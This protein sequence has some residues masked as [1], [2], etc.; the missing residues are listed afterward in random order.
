MRDIGRLLF[1]YKEVSGLFGLFIAAYIVQIFVVPASSTTLQKY[2]LSELQYH[3]VL[4]TVAI[5]YIVI[6]VIA[7]VGYLRLKAYAAVLGK[8]RDG[9]AFQLISK[10]VFWFTLWLP[11]STLVGTLGSYAYRDHVDFTANVV[12]MET[13]ANLI[14]LIPAFVYVYQGSVWLLKVSKSRLTNPTFMT[15]LSFIVFAAAYTFVVLEDSAR[16][17]PI[18][19]D[20]P[21][22]YYMPDWLIVV[23]VVIPRLIMWYLGILAV[24]NIVLYRQKVS[25]VIYRSALQSLAKGLGAVTLMIILLRCLQSFNNHMNKLSLAALL[26]VVYLLL[27]FM[28]VGYVWIARGAKQLQTIEEA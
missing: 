14:L 28:A 25:G 22:T 13:Y 7:L 11:L 9:Q 23:S 18:G 1:R 6:W 15:S 20:M 8:S 26:L 4:L 27:I 10:G 16:R 17:I 24:Q 19:P 5:P 2:H 12:R 21:A 3:E